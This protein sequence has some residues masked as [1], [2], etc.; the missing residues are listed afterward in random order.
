MVNDIEKELEAAVDKIVDLTIV[1]HVEGVRRITTG[2][3][4]E[5]TDSLI[6]MELEYKKHWWSLKT[7]KGL[8]IC[9][10][11]ASSIL[12]LFVAEEL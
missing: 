4:L 5:V 2:K 8:Y 1:H 6:K 9:N 7:Y 3:L 11:K 10:R 12:S